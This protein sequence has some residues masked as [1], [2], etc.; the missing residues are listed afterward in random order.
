MMNTATPQTIAEISSAWIEEVLRSAG[1]IG[2]ERVVSIAT[3][4]IGEGQGFL[5]SMAVVGITYDG[6]V[7]GGP[8][9]L[10]VKLEPAAGAFRDTERET[11]AFAREVNFYRDVAP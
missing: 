3:R 10:V 8:A 7:P 6:A 9:G 2:T 11:K 1:V 4:P 5:S